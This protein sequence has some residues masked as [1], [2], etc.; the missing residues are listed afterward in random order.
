ML[1]NLHRVVVGFNPGLGQVS[2]LPPFP[3]SSPHRPPPL[4]PLRGLSGWWAQCLVL[5]VSRKQNEVLC[6]YNLGETHTGG[7]DGSSW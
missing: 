3:P 2:P 5:W 4:P 6:T 7:G 1:E